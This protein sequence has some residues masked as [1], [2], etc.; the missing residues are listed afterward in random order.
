MIGLIR[1]RISQDIYKSS[2]IM[3]SIVE[4]HSKILSQWEEDLPREMQLSE[5]LMGSGDEFSQ[6]HQIPLAILHIMFRGA[7][8]IV[9]PRLLTAMAACGIKRQWSLD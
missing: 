3:I 4:K 1:A 8:M 6:P 5:L 2:S 7:Q 9:Q